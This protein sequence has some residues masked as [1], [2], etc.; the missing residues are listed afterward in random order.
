MDEQNQWD[1]FFQNFNKPTDTL[2][3]LPGDEIEVAC[4]QILGEPQNNGVYHG[5][6][7]QYRSENQKENYQRPPSVTYISEDWINGDIKKAK[8]HEDDHKRIETAWQIILHDN[9]MRA[10]QGKKTLSEYELI[11]FGYELIGLHCELDSLENP[12]YDIFG[13]LHMQRKSNIL[14]EIQRILDSYK[15]KIKEYDNVQ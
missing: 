3:I 5:C 13:N 2:K 14:S 15:M 11:L 7:F 12:D 10:I 8:E 4:R 1:A 6:T 9:E